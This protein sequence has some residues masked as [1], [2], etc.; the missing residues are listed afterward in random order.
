MPQL[1][2]PALLK[3]IKGSELFEIAR[4][5]A[6]TADEQTVAGLLNSWL[7][8]ETD[9]SLSGVEVTAAAVLFDSLAM[10]CPRAADRARGEYSGRP[11]RSWRDCFPQANVPAWFE[12]LHDRSVG[13]DSS[14]SFE[15]RRHL[16]FCDYA[17]PLL[18]EHAPERLAGRHYRFTV[19][20][21][22]YDGDGFEDGM[23][24][25]PCFQTNSLSALVA[26][27]ERQTPAEVR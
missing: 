19:Y 8:S 13:G 22:T 16:I 5:I 27:T 3:K 23:D 11:P 14:P 18:S 17:N 4:F 9:D 24:D 21:L 26:W 7:C 25:E 12:N 10:L 15:F 2:T 6:R 1:K 20:P